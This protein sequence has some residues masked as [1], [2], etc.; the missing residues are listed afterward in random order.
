MAR[1]LLKIPRTVRKG[2]SFDIR[3]LI[4]HPMESGQRRD[5]GGQVI[6]RF[7]INR[8]SCLY[9][10]E[11]VFEADLFPAIAANPF[12]EFSAVAVNSGRIVMRWVDDAGVGQT[13]TADIV[14]T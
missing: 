8:F 2:E 6:P 12:F 3:I 4:A 10:G 13:E 5:E 11:L 1:V 14:V 9:N 7:I